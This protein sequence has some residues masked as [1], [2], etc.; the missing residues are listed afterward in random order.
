M[1]GDTASE[2]IVVVKPER[3]W[4]IR[5]CHRLMS[6]E[7]PNSVNRVKRMSVTSL[8]RP[9]GRSRTSLRRPRTGRRPF[10]QGAGVGGADA[11]EL[12][13]SGLRSDCRRRSFPGRR[14]TGNGAEDER[15]GR[16]RH[17]PGGEGRSTIPLI[18]F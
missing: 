14:A 5:M 12:G 10:D 18:A 7:E 9:H 4:Q 3:A 16:L 2:A 8:A 15:R 6:M 11:I 1:A 13:R 17:R